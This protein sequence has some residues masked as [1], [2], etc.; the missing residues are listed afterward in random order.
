VLDLVHQSHHTPAAV[1][2]R[3]AGV[4]DVVAF[5]YWSLLLLLLLSLLLYPFVACT[6]YADVV[7]HRLLAAAIGIAPLPD[8]LRDQELLHDCSGR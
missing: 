7:V 8:D 1:G 5:A 4:A 6:R 3:A 2:P